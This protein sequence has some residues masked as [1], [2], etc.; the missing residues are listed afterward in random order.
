[1]LV[2]AYWLSADTISYPLSTSKLSGKSI[3]RKHIQRL[4]TDRNTEIYLPG[5]T[6]FDG[7]NGVVFY[8]HV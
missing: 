1:M 2:V 8:D 4:S 7:A 5:I 3:N 6:L